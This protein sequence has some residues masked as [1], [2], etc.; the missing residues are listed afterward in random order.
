[1]NSFVKSSSWA[2]IIR[3]LLFVLFGLLTIFISSTNIYGPMFY[4]GILFAI[5]GGIYVAVSFLLR[6]GNTSWLWGMGWGLIDLVIGIY[7]LTKTETA[8]DLL[9]TV[10]GAWAVVMALALII[11][12]FQAPS[13]KIFLFIN[14]LVSL[15]FGL[16]ILFNPFPAGFLNFIIGLY[17]LLFGLTII[18]LGVKIRSIGNNKQEKQHPIQ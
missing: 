18:Y 3:G 15:G 8:T 5:S 14:A 2:L 6:K 12:G 13:L 1:M 16:L 7:I 4:L 17:A 11:A 9:T 10:I